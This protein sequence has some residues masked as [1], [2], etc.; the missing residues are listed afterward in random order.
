MAAA[1]FDVVALVTSAGGLSALNQVLLPLPDDLGVAVVI[2][3]H[4]QGWRRSTRPGPAAA[5]G[6]GASRR[7]DAAPRRASPSSGDPGRR[8]SPEYA[9]FALEHRVL[10]PDGTLAWTLS[11]AVPLLDDRGEIIE[12]VGAAAEVPG[13]TNVEPAGPPTED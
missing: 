3:Q 7:D 13:R 8:R 6:P 2:V 5:A 10:R 11:R 12:W 4:G 9:I 1:P